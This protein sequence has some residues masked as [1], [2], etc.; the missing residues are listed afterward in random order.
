MVLAYG[1]SGLRESI[2]A[3]SIQE[4]KSTI[5]GTNFNFLIDRK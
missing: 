5:N 2:G 3:F 4:V 1:P